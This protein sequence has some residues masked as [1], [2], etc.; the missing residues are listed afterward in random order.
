MGTG[1]RKRTLKLWWKTSKLAVRLV[2]PS[3]CRSAQWLACAASTC[4][5]ACLANIGAHYAHA[6]MTHTPTRQTDQAP[7]ANT[8]HGILAGNSA[9][10]TS[11][12]THE[13]LYLA[14]WSQPSASAIL[15]WHCFM[16]EQSHLANRLPARQQLGDKE[17]YLKKNSEHAARRAWPAPGDVHTCQLLYRA[18]SA[19]RCTA[20]VLMYPCLKL[21][22]TPSQLCGKAPQL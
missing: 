3:H 14:H 8:S 19:P 13:S 16:L 20:P 2:R 5:C 1:I 12:Q 21:A 9:H 11:S 7:A 6:C 22:N 10:N 4:F 18:W 17:Q 15:P